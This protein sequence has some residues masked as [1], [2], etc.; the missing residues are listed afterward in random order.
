MFWKV[1]KSLR[2]PN[3]S[4][5][6]KKIL[7]SPHQLLSTSQRIRDLLD[8]KKWLNVWLFFIRFKL[9]FWGL[10]RSYWIIYNCLKV[11][12]ETERNFNISFSLLESCNHTSKHNKN[13]AK[14]DLYRIQQIWKTR[15]F[16][17]L[18]AVNEKDLCWNHGYLFLKCIFVQRGSRILTNLFLSN[19]VK[20][21]M[22][23]KC[24]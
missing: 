14:S 17:K 8:T 12:P 10:V 23:L 22:A 11:S 9:K 19:L 18:L 13:L 21:F 20:E 3:W 5:V 15:I 4:E 7:K 24:Q 16:L 6:S 2:C 1:N